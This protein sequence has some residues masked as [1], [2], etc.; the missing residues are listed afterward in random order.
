MKIG[1]CGTMS[2][3]KTTFVNYLEKNFDL[4]YKFFTERSQYLKGL[5]IPL[6]LDSTLKG[7]SIFLAERASE[8]LNDNFITDRSVIDVMAFTR[9]ADSI[10]PSEKDDFE[11]HAANLI[12]E[13]D[14]ILY[15]PPGDIKIEDNGVRETDADYRSSID[16]EIQRLLVK[17]RHKIKNLDTLEGKNKSRYITFMSAYNKLIK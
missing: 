13:Y 15:V 4:G 9:H 5:G 11:A 12:N 1:L 17:Y 8:L 14:L 6:N 2:V 10:R 3:G 7:Q 16:Q